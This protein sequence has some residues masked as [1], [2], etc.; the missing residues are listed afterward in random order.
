MILS[1]DARAFQRPQNLILLYYLPN[2]IPK[3]YFSNRKKILWIQTKTDK[4]MLYLSCNSHPVSLE[5]KFWTY[6]LNVMSFCLIRSYWYKG[7]TST[8]NFNSP[9]LNY[10]FI[11]P[12]ILTTIV[13]NELITNIIR[14]HSDT[15][16]RW[17]TH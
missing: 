10:F 2:T 7:N 14:K 13:R 4:L 9:A 6:I 3:H 17:T 1:K 8:F 16:E 5:L 11:C 12:G 15:R